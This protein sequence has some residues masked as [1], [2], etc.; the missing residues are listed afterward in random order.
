LTPPSPPS[1]PSL[2]LFFEFPL[3]ATPLNKVFESHAEKL[4]NAIPPALFLR[5]SA[6][7]EAVAAKEEVEVAEVEEMRREDLEGEVDLGGVKRREFRGAGVG[8]MACEHGG[9]RGGA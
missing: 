7:A 5:F 4:M 3:G 8:E 1:S 6:G 2:P 9:G